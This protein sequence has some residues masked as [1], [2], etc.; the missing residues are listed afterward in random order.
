M[1]YHLQ[2]NCGYGWETI[3]TYAENDYKEAL[4]DLDSYKE[5]CPQWHYR[6]LK[7]KLIGMEEK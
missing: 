2:E 5:N 6:L 3:I 7:M 4:D 1:E